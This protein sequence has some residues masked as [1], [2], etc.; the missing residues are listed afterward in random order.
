MSGRAPRTLIVALLAVAL[1]AIAIAGCGSSS[2]TDSQ[3]RK[4]AARICAGAGRRT[5][6]IAAP[7]D[8]AQEAS[9]L[10]QGIAVY[11]PI[12]KALGRLDP[13]DDLA[14][15]YHRALRQSTAELAALRSS[16]TGLRHD[17]DAVVAIK[18]LQQRLGP[19]ETRATAA[20]QAL[21]LP[22]CR[23]LFG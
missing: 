19:V 15:D 21:E 7:T 2:L 4:R 5:A 9:F 6:A 22:A 20:W 3:L 8:P 11:A 1:G 10:K 17:N 18:T 12:L 16:L 13:S 14:G 23:K